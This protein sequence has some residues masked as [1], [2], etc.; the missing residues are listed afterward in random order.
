MPFRT[1]HSRTRKIASR[2]I[3]TLMF[4]CISPVTY[5]VDETFCTLNFAPRAMGNAELG[6]ASKQ[7][8]W[9]FKGGGEG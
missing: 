6:Q 4:C 9:R 7:V 8:V 1:A 2:R 3:K 5:N